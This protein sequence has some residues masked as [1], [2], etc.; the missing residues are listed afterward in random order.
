V[1]KEANRLGM[2]INISHG[3][4]ETISQAI[5][6]STDPLLA[7]HHGLRSVNNIPRTMPDELVKKLASKGGV[8]GFQIG[9]EFH[10]VKVFKWVTQRAGKPF[11]DTTEIGRKEASMTIEEIDKLAA[12]QFPMI[13]QP[14]PEDLKFTPSTGSPSSSAPSPWSARITSC[15]VRISTAVR[16]CR[17]ACATYATCHC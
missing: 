17:A 6:V 2:V 4:D 3:S 9:N 7:T 15:S 10:N 11:W 8:I 16:R 5:D 12:P 13:G 1:I 14:A